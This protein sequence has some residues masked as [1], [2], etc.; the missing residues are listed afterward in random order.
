ME[1]LLEQFSVGLF[2]WQTVLFVVLII[3]LRA[4]AWK[5]ILEA[6]GEREQNIANALKEAEKAREELEN[7]QSSNESLLKEARIERDNILKEAKEIKEKTINDSK[8]KAKEEAEKIITAAKETINTEK[9]AAMAELKNEVASMS[10]EIAEKILG[11]ELSSD[12]KQ[13]KL[14]DNLTD[15]VTMN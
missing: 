3:V 11:E 13:K 12:A 14:I 2:F 4:F 6:V 7:L 1:S 9:L 5:P 10:I 15:E 8:E